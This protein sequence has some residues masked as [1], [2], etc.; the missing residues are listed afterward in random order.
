MIDPVT[1]PLIR[2]AYER[3]AEH[4]WSMGQLCTEWNSRPRHVAVCV[5]QGSETPVCG[6]PRG[7][8]TSQDYQRSINSDDKK[9]GVKTHVKGTKWS[10]STLGKMLKKATLKG[11]AMHRGE[12]LLRDGLPVRWAD[13]ILTDEEFDKLQI[14]VAALGRYR[15]G[16]KPNASPM[17]GVL[18]C[19]CGMKMYENSS[20]AKLRTGEVKKHKYFCCA[21]WSNGDACRYSTSWPQSEIY[22]AVEESFLSKPRRTYKHGQVAPCMEIG[23]SVMGKSTSAVLTQLSAICSTNQT[24]SSP[25]WR[26]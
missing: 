12:P 14:A 16:I 1:G 4:G 25:T 19:P 20:P 18:H 24:S 7:V 5:E 6:C 26:S 8:L 22:R 11:V 17:T 23:R 15:A 9:V 2:E 3:V 10:T 21:S 13:P